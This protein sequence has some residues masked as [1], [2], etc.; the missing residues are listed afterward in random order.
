MTSRGFT[1]V[2]MAVVMVVVALLAA[3][4]TPSLVEVLVN[5][6]LRAAG[7]DLVSSLYLAR[8][9]AI[10]RNANVTVQPATGAGW[11]EGWVVLADD[12]A[13]LDRKTPAGNRVAVTR[14]PGT[15]VF[16]PSGRIDPLGRA[17]VEFS[18][19]AGHPGISSRCVTVETTGLPRLEARPCA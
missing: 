7:S 17:R 18:D 5:Q 14:A 12:G 15:I 4:A 10:K 11:V 3:V 6:R 9:E 16:T 1:L 19:A 8:S 13:Q 2:E